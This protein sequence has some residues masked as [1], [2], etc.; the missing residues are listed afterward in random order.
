MSQIHLQQDRSQT[1]GLPPR[2]ELVA[3]ITA[4]IREQQPLDTDLT[5]VILA[6][7]A[8]QIDQ[9]STPDMLE[10]R[11][12]LAVDVDDQAPLIQRVATII[13]AILTEVEHWKRG[14]SR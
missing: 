4:T 10:L 2:R 12:Q 14:A 1:D 3:S 9:L 13:D 5:G 11:A 6:G 8:R 7:V